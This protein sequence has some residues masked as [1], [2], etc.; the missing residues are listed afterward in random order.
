[1][2]DPVTIM[3]IATAG[4]AYSSYRAGQETKKG[5][6]AEQKRAEVQNIRNVRAQIREARAA[7][8]QMTNVAAQAGGMG[9]SALAGGLSSVQS[10]LAGNIN[11][12]AAIAEQNTAIS[13]AAISASGWQTT[14][15][16]FGAVGKGAEMYRNIYGY[17][18]TA[19]AASDN[20]YSRG[21]G[22]QYE[23][24]IFGGQFTPYRRGM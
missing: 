9:S 15:T 4:S 20:G 1:M 18:T 12:M 5:Y 22:P 7:Q 14:G 10:Q 13:N 16:I 24:T 8:G 11:Y 17:G 23:G 3:T 21:V 6:Q 2:C 19:S